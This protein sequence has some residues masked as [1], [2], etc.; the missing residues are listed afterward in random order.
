MAARGAERR[1]C[2]ACGQAYVVPVGRV[3]STM[4]FVASG[5][6]GCLVSIDGHEVHRCAAVSD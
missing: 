3:P 6:R 5:H 2:V 1:T 4:F